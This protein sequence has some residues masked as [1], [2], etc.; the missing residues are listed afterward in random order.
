MGA[1]IAMTLLI[2]DPH[3]LGD[4]TLVP[5]AVTGRSEADMA[6]AMAAAVADAEFASAAD[7]LQHLRQA[8]PQAPLGTRVAAA[9]VL[10]ERLRRVLDL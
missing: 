6:H 8:F 7:V 2:H 10:M 9:N 4:V 5:K 3:P 1:P